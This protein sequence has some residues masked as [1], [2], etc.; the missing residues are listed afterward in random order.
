M[1]PLLLV[2]LLALLLFGA[3][4]AVKILW[5]VAVIVLAVWLIGFVARGT[6][7]S[8]NRHRWYRW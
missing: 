5:W 1:V 4:F 7:P 6:H 2:L 8:G 3:G